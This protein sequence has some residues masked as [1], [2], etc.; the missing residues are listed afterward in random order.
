MTAGITIARQEGPSV[1]LN[2]TGRKLRTFFKWIAVST[3]SIIAVFAVL[4]GSV[5][6][7]DAYKRAEYDRNAAGIS[8][9][10]T[11]D[12]RWC[13]DDNFPIY[14]YIKNSS[15]KP[16]E[17]ITLTLDAYGTDRSLNVAGYHLYS[18]DNIIGQGGSRT[19]CWAAYLSEKSD[20][21]VLYW[22]VGTKSFRFGD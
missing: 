12:K 20:P 2:P 9:Q 6:A 14:I 4:I 18:F 1:G 3:F 17:G 19:F 15:P 10:I 22:T 11:A 16:L 13:D 5:L 8:F 21:R 7:Y